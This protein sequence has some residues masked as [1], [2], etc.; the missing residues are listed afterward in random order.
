LLYGKRNEFDFQFKK[1]MD[2]DFYHPKVADEFVF[3]LDKA[4]P[5]TKIFENI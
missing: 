3:N 4:K 2:I 5:K 1:V